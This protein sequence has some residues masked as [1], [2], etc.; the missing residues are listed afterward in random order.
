VAQTAM[1]DAMAKHGRLPKILRSRL[2]R[3]C[4]PKI[5]VS[6]RFP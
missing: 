1:K 5:T 4:R 2:P 6:G 3:R